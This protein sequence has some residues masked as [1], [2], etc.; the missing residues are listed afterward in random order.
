MVGFGSSGVKT[1]GYGTRELVM[2]ILGKYVV[3]MP[4]G[5]NWVR[6]VSKAK[7]GISGVKILSFVT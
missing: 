6:N 2:Q 4:A 1:S 3:R 5:T 7:F